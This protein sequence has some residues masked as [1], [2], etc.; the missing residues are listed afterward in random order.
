[1]DNGPFVSCLRAAGR[2]IL[3]VGEQR[4]S[5]GNPL[6]A[7]AR[8][9]RSVIHLPPRG[10]G[11]SRQQPVPG[12]IPSSPPGSTKIHNS[13]ECLIQ[14][15]PPRGHPPEVPTGR[16]SAPDAT[17]LRSKIPNRSSPQDPELD[18]VL[19]GYRQT[20][21]SEVRGYNP[22]HTPR[23]QHASAVNA[24]RPVR[25]RPGAQ[26]VESDPDRR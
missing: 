17:D 19:G 22:R 14:E 23:R 21:R 25:I 2:G 10:Q 8:K 9:T 15:V 11:R 6:R 4:T 1:M 12:R 3:S 5:G 7:R 26:G 18:L 24:S 13:T 16:V 20:E